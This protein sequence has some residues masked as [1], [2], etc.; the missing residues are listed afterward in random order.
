[1]LYGEYVGEIAAQLA[2]HFQKANLFEKACHYLHLAGEQAV[3][4]YA[5]SEAVSYFN[6]ALALT[7]ET[8]PE[9]RLLFQLRLGETLCGLN[10]YP[11]AKET[12]TAALV[13]ARAQQKGTYATDALYWLSR[14]AVREGNYLEAQN[15]LE[16]S[17]SLAQSGPNRASLTRVLFG[18]GDL[19]WRQGNLTQAQ[20]Y[21][22]ESLP[23]A[24]ELNDTT[25]ELYVLNLLG[26]VADLQGNLDKAQRLYEETLA[27]AQQVG[28]RDR[29]A[30]VLNNLGVLADERG[31]IAAAQA[32]LQQAL[33]LAHEIGNQQFVALLVNN[34][35]NGAIR[36][37]DWVG[38]RRHLQEGLS[39]AHRLG[40][41]PTV[42][43]AVKNIGWLL[44][45]QGQS[46]QGLALLGL[47]LYHPATDHDNIKDVQE[48]LSHLG[49]A[50]DDP[51]VIA[52]LEVGK[53]LDLD[54]AVGDVLAE[55]G[56]SD[57]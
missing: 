14:V 6:R 21:C 37:G 11:A 38:A 8:E 47:V 39:L 23:V 56:R 20:A 32:Y 27:L 15:C 17:L 36:L 35:A 48:A 51:V 33:A 4:Q 45:Q 42:L 10:D 54:E 7:P 26:I 44:A 41:T 34:L 30:L 22:E 40:A 2:L 9:T 1:M 46:E 12:L 31:D 49:L 29:A 50:V 18:L 43:H 53:A 25:Q 5:N 13:A 16:E 52:G 19:S 3:R 24:R 55:L 57:P 28:N